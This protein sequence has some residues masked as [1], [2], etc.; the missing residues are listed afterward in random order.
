MTV[1]QIRQREVDTA[2]PNE[3]VRIA[4]QRMAARCVGTL[5]VVDRQSRPIGILTDRDVAVR[6][7]AESRDPAA[8]LVSD[9]MTPDPKTVHEKASV[10]EALSLMRAHA[11]RRLAVVNHNGKLTGIVSLDDVFALLADELRQVGGVLKS[12]SPVELAKR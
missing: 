7:V 10:E 3:T 4:A 5:L 12:V 11:I 8:T 2:E 9:V 6:V 1:S